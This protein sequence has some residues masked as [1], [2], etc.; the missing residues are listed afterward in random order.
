MDL[1]LIQRTGIK[2][3]FQSA[4]ILRSHF[5]HISSVTHKGEIDLVTCA[6]TQSEEAIIKIIKDRFPDHSILAEESGTDI[7]NPDYQWI[8]DPL[9]GTTNFAHH[10]HLYCIS[11]AFS[12][13]GEV[14][15]GVVLAPETGELFTAI[16][17]KGATLNT[18]SIHVSKQTKISSS[19][20]VTGFPYSFREHT[21][22]IISRFT[23]CLSASQGV[24][25][26]GSAALDLCY[27]ASGRF[28]AFWEEYLKPWD[29]AAGYLIA[30]E[31]G[32]SV[33]NFSGN[34]YNVTH[35]EI[36][37]TNSHIHSQMLDLLQLRE[38]NEK[39]R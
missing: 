34:P 29:T 2:A 30:L 18:K 20:L 32:A 7:K 36:L 23:N 9:D 33:T 3:A 35:L 24:R 39:K 16:K 11:I 37:A 38:Y 10:I 12:F 6:D 13:K 26:L 27:V 15:V 14:V 5:G 17:G 4:T 25:R 31:A 19:L 8:I 21:Q 28:E 22:P 1:E